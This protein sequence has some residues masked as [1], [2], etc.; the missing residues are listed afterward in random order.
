MAGYFRPVKPNIII[1]HTL[2]T[3]QKSFVNGIQK[4]FVKVIQK[5]IG[6]GIQESPIMAERLSQA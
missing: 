1:T 4:I 3:I 5:E 6:M 2:P